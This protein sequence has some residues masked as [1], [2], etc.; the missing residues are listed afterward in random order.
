VLLSAFNR[1]V[2]A[3]GYLTQLGIWHDNEFNQYNLSCDLLEPF[4]TVVDEVAFEL[5]LGDRLFKKKMANIL[6]FTAVVNGKTTTLD[7]AIRTFT[8]GVL[9]ALNKDDPSL[10]VYPE[11][12]KI[13]E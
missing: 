4:R 12:I 5:P 3:S 10:I 1:E 13:N 2:V 7:L 9:A 11:M 8:H 6:N